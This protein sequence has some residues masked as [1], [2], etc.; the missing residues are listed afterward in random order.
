MISL[1]SK[2]NNIVHK[3]VRV[4]SSKRKISSD[5]KEQKINSFE[6]MITNY[7]KKL[8][9]LKLK[10]IR[11]KSI[12]EENKNFNNIN[13]SKDINN[14]NNSN[15]KK[16]ELKPNE[17]KEEKEE[18]NINKEIVN[19]NNKN[20]KN[21]NDKKKHNES[22]LHSNNGNLTLNSSMNIKSMG[23]N[24]E[25]TQLN[26]NISN[27]ISNHISNNKIHNQSNIACET[28]NPSQFSIIQ[29]NIPNNPPVNNDNSS[30]KKPKLNSKKKSKKQI[31]ENLTPIPEYPTPSESNENIGNYDKSKIP[32]EML[33][34]FNDIPLI[35]EITKVENE[36]GEFIIEQK[37]LLKYMEQYPYVPK[38]FSIKYPSGEKYSGYF[39]PDWEK[40]V[41]GVQI[42]K[43]GS[44]YVGMFKNGMHDGR[45][46]LILHKGD[47]YEGEFKENKAN[48]FGKYVNIKGEIYIGNW[49]DDKQ[50]GEGE[51]I[52][53]DGSRYSGE[54][55]NGMKNGKGKIVWT[56]SSY[57]EG[58]FVNNYFDGYGVYM[59]RNKKN[60]I[61]E[62]KRGQMN[63][64]GI[65]SSPDGKSYKGYY[66]N[67]KKHGF[68]IYSGKNNIRYEGKFK[69]GKQYGVG[70]TINEK[71]EKQLG[72]YLKGKRLKFLNEKDFKDDV[73]NIDKEVEKINNI[74][75]HDEFFVKNIGLLTMI[76]EQY[77]KTDD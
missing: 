11:E 49:I 50:D 39:S 58:N 46:R 9:L 55:K 61:G 16:E 52:L 69:K 47:Y 70:R 20:N 71:G 64:F 53:K 25:D 42:N 51:L 36:I 7:I 8:F 35:D 41:F 27:N 44:K 33:F 29:N 6:N 28:P 22:N 59:M 54:F 56:D 68:G 21:E 10:I 23:N 66:E 34:N 32:G 45:G 14:G 75:E 2:T 60:Y 1:C 40:E 4:D 43:D 62:W 3:E 77:F 48:G 76:Q 38:F 12:E 13:N 17:K 31:S 57:Y 65:F 24:E 63:G 18:D 37:E 30:Q 73:D 67:D 72:L 26:D 19:K 5:S 74:I 15:E